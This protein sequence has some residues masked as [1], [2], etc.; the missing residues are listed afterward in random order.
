MDGEMH[1][2]R[3]RCTRGDAHTDEEMHTWMERCPQ[4]TTTAA[5]CAHGV[6]QEM[7]HWCFL[8]KGHGSCC[9]G[10][11]H[12]G[13]GGLFGGQEELHLQAQPAFRGM[14]AELQTIQHSDGGRKDCSSPSY[15]TAP[16][17]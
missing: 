12:W 14:K 16:G 10:R 13:L 8:R 11:K 17:W 5:V 2:W 9:K 7:W 3:Q 15:T 1:T 6:G 4:S